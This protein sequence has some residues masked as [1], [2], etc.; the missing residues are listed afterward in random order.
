MGSLFADILEV[1][2]HGSIVILA[3]A[4]LRLVLK[5]A[6][7]NTVCLLWLLAAVRLLMPFQISSPMSLQPDLDVG[8]RVQTQ[9]TQENIMESPIFDETPSNAIPEGTSDRTDDAVV[10]TG[11]ATSGGTVVDRDKANVVIDSMALAGWVWL[12]GVGVL[13]V[14]AIVSYVNLKRRMEKSGW[15]EDGLYRCPGLD[16]A[17]VLGFVKPRIC[18][19]QGVDADVLRYVV[20]HERAHIARK[21]HIW[22]LFGF[23]VLTVHWFNPLVWLAYSLYCKD[24][25][26]A[27]DERVVRGMDTAQRKAYS[28]ALVACA[29]KGHALGVC[30]V[31]FGEI[32]VKGRVKAVLNYKRPKFWIIL[33]A[34][35]A[36]IAVAVCFLTSP[37]MTEEEILDHFY[38]QMD[39]LQNQ[40]QIHLIVTEELETD[41]PYLLDRQQEYWISGDDWYGVYAY[42]FTQ[43]HYEIRV[44]QVDGIQ[45]C[46]KHSDDFE[47]ADNGIWQDVDE[48]DYHNMAQLLTMDWT[49][50]TV[51]EIRREDGGFSLIVQGYHADESQYTTFENYYTFHL[52]RDGGL[53]GVTRYDR[54]ETI[55]KVF[56]LSGWFETATTV[57][58]TFLD[59][60][61]AAFCELVNQ[62][63]GDIVSEGNDQ[64][65]GDLK[66]EQQDERLRDTNAWFQNLHTENVECIQL[67][68]HECVDNSTYHHYTGQELADLIGI[69]NDFQSNEMI[70][71]PEIY[72]GGTTVTLCITMTDGTERTITNVCNRY[73]SV[74]GITY[75]VDAEWLQ[76]WPHKGDV[77]ASEVHHS[78]HHGESHH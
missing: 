39:K 1:S 2:F 58:Y 50:A 37:A 43:G 67:T 29:A 34:V 26:M 3:V 61:N 27:C 41:N 62:A 7:R 24:L 73:V 9:I 14:Y 57:T 69:L 32:D 51:E 49:E 76:C 6:P 21:D 46:C 68:A 38:A 13:S 33:L 44:A 54:S 42:D 36:L 64:E 47:I 25:E 55:H 5:G 71:D 63:F 17:F 53:V 28:M 72:F 75:Q 66:L 19:P 8:I 78:Q 31:A 45:K 56:D 65:A 70:E 10:S 16:S 52:D 48:S 12:A 15:L 59:A 74:D 60:D 18:L 35:A 22:K 77:D 4:V 30:P 23:G 40:E 20:A 11:D